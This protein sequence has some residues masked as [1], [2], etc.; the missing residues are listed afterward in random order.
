MHHILVK[1]PY[2]AE[3]CTASIFR[4]SELLQLD[5][6]VVQRKNCTGVLTQFECVWSLTDHVHCSS[7]VGT[8]PHHH[9]YSYF[10]HW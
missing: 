9:H 3:E 4:V 5:A 10:S 1:Y 7:T 2:I 8:D 6:E